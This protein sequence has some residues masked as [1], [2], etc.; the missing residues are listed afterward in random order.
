MTNVKVIKVKKLI[1]DKIEQLLTSDNF[2]WFYNPTT[3]YDTKN[4]RKLK[5]SENKFDEK[6]TWQ[7]TH[8]FYDELYNT[9]SYYYENSEKFNIFY[10]K[11]R[12]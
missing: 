8:K 9:S 6:D 10:V 12:L 5:F 2:G 7:F 11:L 3:I 4:I 1:Q